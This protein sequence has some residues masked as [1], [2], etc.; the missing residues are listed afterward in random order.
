MR[1]H[2]ME[3]GGVLATPTN[4]S[5]FSCLPGSQSPHRLRHSS[6]RRAFSMLSS[7]S[8]STTGGRH[9]HHQEQIVRHSERCMFN[10]TGRESINC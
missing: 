3:H 8:S 5:L 10:W 1:S 2:S 7:S 6:L 9:C 4:T